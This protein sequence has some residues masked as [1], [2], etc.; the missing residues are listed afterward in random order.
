MKGRSY[1]R[2]DLLPLKVAWKFARTGFRVDV[3]WLSI[4]FE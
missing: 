4:S 3:E 1:L 2:I